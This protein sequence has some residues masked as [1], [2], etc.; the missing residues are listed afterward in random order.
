MADS[1][2]HLAQVATAQAQKE[3]T[4]NGLFDAA[5]LATFGGRR[6]EAC[7]GLVWGYYGGRVGGTLVA[8]GT[9][10]L[11]ASTTNYIIANRSTGTVSLADSSPNE[12]IDTAFMRLY[13]V[14]TGSA[15][16][17]S[18]EDHRLGDNGVF[19]T[20][21]DAVSFADI[22]DID[23][24]GSPSPVEGDVLA[25]DAANQVWRHRAPVPLVAEISPIG[26]HAVPVV[27]G[28]MRPSV[29]GGCAA[30]A[31]VISASDQPDLITL[32]FDPTTEEY[33]Q[34]SVPMPKSW[35]EG[36]ITFKALWSHAATTTNFGVAWGLQGVAIGNDDTIAVSYGTA[37]VVT[38]TGGTT[39]D[40][41]VTS[42]SAAIT[43]AGSPAA[44]D[45]VFFRVYRAP[46]NGSDTMAI[47]ARLHAIVLFITT[48]AATDA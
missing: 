17:T 40:L 31:S 25:F 29:V 43:I 27:A 2:T 12:W 15:S 34:F 1:T 19:S 26:R 44:E 32:N 36:T 33:A 24:S 7:A 6:A 4:V 39:N 13:K 3:V 47:D 42:E 14:V 11:P 22:S 5:S 35:N 21:A 28:S 48:S 41:Y 8:N 9:I 20:R 16:V 38:D 10:T 46:A 23:T 37:Q 18:Y 45:M 30:L